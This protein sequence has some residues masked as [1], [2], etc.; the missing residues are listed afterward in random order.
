MYDQ[1]QGISEITEGRRGESRHF[2]E[3]VLFREG[4][5]FQQQAV[6][7][8][9][10]PWEGEQHFLFIKS[11]RADAVLRHRYRGNLF[12]NRHAFD[13]GDVIE[14]LLVELKGVLALPI[15]VET[16]AVGG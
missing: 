9:R 6:P 14:Q 4:E 8:E 10:L 13:A 11:H 1:I 16:D 7:L 12:P 2:Q 15:E 5:V 3:E